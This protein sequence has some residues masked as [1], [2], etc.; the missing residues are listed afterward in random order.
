MCLDYSESKH[1]DSVLQRLVSYKCSTYLAGSRTFPKLDM[2]YFF[3]VKTCYCTAE[4]AI[5]RIV[6]NAFP[7]R[8]VQMNTI[9]VS[10]GSA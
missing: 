6:Q 4:Y 3:Y 5:L 9:S 7:N 10:L 1:R 2:L 8:L